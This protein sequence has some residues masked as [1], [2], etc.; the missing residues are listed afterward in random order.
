[1]YPTQLDLTFLIFTRL[2]RLLTIRQQSHIC[3][4]P[5]TEKTLRNNPLQNKR[6]KECVLFPQTVITPRA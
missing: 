6:K 1:M 3:L 4:P 5:D 2:I